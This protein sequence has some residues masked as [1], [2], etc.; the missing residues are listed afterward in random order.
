MESQVSRS[1][2]LGSGA[3]AMEQKTDEQDQDPKVAPVGRIQRSQSGR[4]L[5]AASPEPPNLGES[6]DRGEQKV[7]G[8]YPPRDSKS[9]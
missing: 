8:R 5:H 6:C 7:D 9:P 4:I 1:Q 3:A 2:A